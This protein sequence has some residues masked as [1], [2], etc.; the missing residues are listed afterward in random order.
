MCDFCKNIETLKKIKTGA[1][2]GGYYPTENKTQ[3][4]YSDIDND[5]NLFVGC[6]DSFYS[7]IELQNIR[8]CPYCG[9]ELVKEC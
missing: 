7:G 6:D 3:I 1:F 8:Y 9:R 5:F 2:R 4:V